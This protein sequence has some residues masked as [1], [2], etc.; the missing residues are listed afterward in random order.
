MREIETIRL[1][2]KKKSERKK[3]N[4][5]K[6]N[7]CISIVSTSSFLLRKLWRR[8]KTRT[9]SD[10]KQRAKKKQQ[11]DHETSFKTK[12]TIQSSCELREASTVDRTTK[13]ETT[14]AARQT[15]LNQ[16]IESSSFLFCFSESSESRPDESR[17]AHETVPKQFLFLFLFLFVK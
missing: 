17:E 2:E 5:Q 11:V 10:Q 8:R 9:R 7:G 14:K 13:R 4:K 3:T 12:K 6:K 1:P 15:K 16:S